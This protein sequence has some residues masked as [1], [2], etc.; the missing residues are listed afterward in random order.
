MIK[1]VIIKQLLNKTDISE[2]IDEDLD[3]SYN[4]AAKNIHCFLSYGKART[5]CVKF[6]IRSISTKKDKKDYNQ[7][8][9]LC[10]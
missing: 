6:A 3:R 10:L 1:G 4:A 7:Y 9:Q 8:I 5:V 2:H